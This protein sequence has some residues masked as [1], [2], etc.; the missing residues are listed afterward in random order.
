M[1]TSLTD[2]YYLKVIHPHCV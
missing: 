1:E 2:I